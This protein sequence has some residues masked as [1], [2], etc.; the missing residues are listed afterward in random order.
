MACAHMQS[1]AQASHCTQRMIRCRRINARH[2]QP[3]DHRTERASVQQ[4]LPSRCIATPPHPVRSRPIQVNSDL[5]P[6]ARVELTGS[7]RRHGQRRSGTASC[8]AVSGLQGALTAT[9]RVRWLAAKLCCR[10]DAQRDRD[11]VHGYG[12]EELQLDAQHARRCACGSRSRSL[13]LLAATRL[14]M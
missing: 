8:C 6:H 9:A 12:E 2:P 4:C 10:A 14:T 5:W 11:H 13:D 7:A 1:S 3:C